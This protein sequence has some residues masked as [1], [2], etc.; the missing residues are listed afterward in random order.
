MRA[1][2]VTVAYE[3]ESDL[4]SSLALVAKTCG[5][6]LEV[7]GQRKA[8]GSGSTRGL[9]DGFLYVAGFCH[10]L[11]A[12]RCKALAGRDGTFSNDQIVA[13]DRRRSE[14]VQTYAPRTPQ[15]LAD[16]IGWSRRNA[17]RYRA[18]CPDCPV[19]PTMDEARRTT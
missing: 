15:H 5:V 6:Y 14:G 3:L 4:M 1:A 12:K 17:G 16:L 19:V 10:P 2:I 18:T 7:A 11:E 8:K 9:P 13:A